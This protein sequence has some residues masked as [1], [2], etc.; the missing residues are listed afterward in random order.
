ML[1]LPTRRLGLRSPGT[2]A[3]VR[4]LASSGPAQ[5][6]YHLQLGLD[7]GWAP[8]GHSDALHRRLALLHLCG[9]GPRAQSAYSDLLGPGP[10]CYH[11]GDPRRNSSRAAAA[12]GG[13]LDPR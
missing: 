1:R 4:A 9:P 13:T 12:G 10:R 11:P 6:A 3:L 7:R 8:P 2:A 5:Q